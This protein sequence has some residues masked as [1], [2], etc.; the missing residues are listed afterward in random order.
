MLQFKNEKRESRPFSL[1]SAAAP[2]NSVPKIEKEKIFPPVFSAITQLST[3]ECYPNRK[4]DRIFGSMSAETCVHKFTLF[5][6]ANPIFLRKSLP[7]CRPSSRCRPV[8]L[9]TS[10]LEVIS[11][12]LSVIRYHTNRKNIKQHP[13]LKQPFNNPISSNRP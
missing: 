4:K 7:N 3:F 12:I 2:T 10:V 13:P 5:H 11:P 8:C 9:S 1:L 6:S